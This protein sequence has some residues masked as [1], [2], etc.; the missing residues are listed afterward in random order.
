MAI[1]RRT[2]NRAFADMSMETRLSNQVVFYGDTGNELDLTATKGVFFLEMLQVEGAGSIDIADGNG[3]VIASGVTDFSN[4]H[5][6]L[7]CEY[8]ITITGSLKIAKGF[9]LDGVLLS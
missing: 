5:S 7:V 8:G 9:V 3:T 4:D 6:P 2:N 1:Y